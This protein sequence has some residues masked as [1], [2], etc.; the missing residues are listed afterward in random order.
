[1]SECAI[2]IVSIQMSSS[3]N[4]H[5]LN[6]SR[7]YVH[8]ANKIC[9]GENTAMFECS[10]MQFVCDNMN[11]IKTAID[12]VAVIEPRII[13]HKHLRC[14]VRKSTTAPKQ[15]SAANIPLSTS[16]AWNPTILSTMTA[17]MPSLV[18]IV[19]LPPKS[20]TSS[21]VGAL[22]STDITTWPR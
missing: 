22:P 8:W 4:E 1:M 9:S 16:L 6:A 14:S 3:G 7:T 17:T 19:P 13:E 5:V 21:L 18:S 12:G 20:R 11:V 2:W 15:S 10:E